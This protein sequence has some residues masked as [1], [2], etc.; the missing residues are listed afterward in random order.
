M[1]IPN[2]EKLTKVSCWVASLSVSL[3]V[4]A[5]PFKLKGQQ[6]HID[7]LCAVE[8]GMRYEMI[9]QSYYLYRYTYM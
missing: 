2:R 8:K 4:C 6:Y 5:V 1:Q 3:W 9:F 7:V